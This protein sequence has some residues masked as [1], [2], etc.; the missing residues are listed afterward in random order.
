MLFSE[1]N[2][3]KLN[4]NGLYSLTFLLVSQKPMPMLSRRQ[5]LTSSHCFRDWP[6]V[7]KEPESKGIQKLNPAYEFCQSQAERLSHW[8]QVEG[9]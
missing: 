4:R 1:Q 3:M 9:Q 5:L 2:N 7:F 6:D 8:Q